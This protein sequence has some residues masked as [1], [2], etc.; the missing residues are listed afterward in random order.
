MNQDQG[1]KAVKILFTII[2]TFFYF[3]FLNVSI[4]LI[5]LK[6]SL[7]GDLIKDILLY[8][9]NSYSPN[10]TEDTLAYNSPSDQINKELNEYEINYNGDINKDI[11]RI[12]KNNNIP[13]E[14]FDYLEVNDEN[15]ELISDV[16]SDYINYTIGA[17][18]ELNFPKKEIKA[19]LDDAI[20]NY[21]KTTNKKINISNIDKLLDEVEKEYIAFAN[22]NQNK[23]VRDIISSLLNGKIFYTIITLT[24]LFL[25]AVILINL[26][27]INVLLTISIPHLIMGITY[28]SIG[29]SLPKLVNEFKAF[30][31]LT[32]NITNIGIALLIIALIGIIIYVILNLRR[33]KSELNA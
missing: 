32:D 21:E 1:V 6:M 9:N 28:I 2:F 15:L 5:I 4:I 25:I 17:T 7:T 30:K 19:L 27:N 14:L 8:S 31:S 3:I 24:I 12:L 29:L 10:I 16:I 22:D 13:E 26:K 11:E 18:N 33:R 20:A 23:E